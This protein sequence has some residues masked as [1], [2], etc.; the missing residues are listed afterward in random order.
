M[1]KPLYKTEL[2]KYYVG[3]SEELLASGLG[4]KLKNNIQLSWTSPLL[5][6]DKNEE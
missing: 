3:N 1:Q 2:G 6:I 5:P 4:K